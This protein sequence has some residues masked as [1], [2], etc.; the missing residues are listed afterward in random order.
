MNATERIEIFAL[1]ALLL[2]AAVGVIWRCAE[3]NSVQKAKWR[4]LIAAEK[5]ALKE[6]AVRSI[7]DISA[8]SAEYLVGLNAADFDPMQV[9]Q[10]PSKLRGSVNEYELV[11]KTSEHLDNRFS[12]I[13][14]VAPVSISGAVTFILGLFAVITHYAKLETASWL[15]ALGWIVGGAGVV[16]MAVAL[17]GWVYYNSSL[18]KLISPS[19]L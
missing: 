9:I 11:L 12:R 17:V 10:D 3:L 5:D 13:L 7:R 2:L 8:R 18:N 14:W 15:F 19:S 16:A 4:P 1:G 6:R